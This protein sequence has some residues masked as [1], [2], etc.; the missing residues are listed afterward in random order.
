[1]SG[2]YINSKTPNP[3]PDPPPHPPIHQLD[4]HL[5]DRIQFRPE[6]KSFLTRCVNLKKFWNLTL[7]VIAQF[8]PI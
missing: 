5:E 4:E 3:P 7:I 6:N 2:L 1:M 8:N